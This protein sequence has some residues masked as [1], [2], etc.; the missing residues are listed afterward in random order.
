[1]SSLVLQRAL[2]LKLLFLNAILSIALIFL[3]RDAFLPVGNMLDASGMFMGRDFV[4]FWVGGHVFR[5]EDFSLL[6]DISAY[7]AEVVHSMGQKA[8]D[9]VWSYPPHAAFLSIPLSFFPYPVALAG[10]E[11]LTL[12][13]LSATL[14]PFIPVTHRRMAAL[15]LLS[16]PAVL[17]VLYMGQNGFLTGAC[18]IGSLLY[19]RKKPWLAGLY[20]GLL[21]IKPQLGLAVFIALLGLKAW[22]ALG[23]G[24]LFT[25]LTL[26]FSLLFHGT[27][28]WIQYLTKTLPHHAA[29]FQEHA[30]EYFMVSPLGCL[31]Q[32]GIPFHTAS[33]LHSALALMAACALPILVIRIK[34]LEWQALAVSIATFLLTPYAQGHD[35]IAIHAAMVLCIFSSTEQRVPEYFTFIFIALWS[36]PF[37]C[38]PEASREIGLSAFVLILSFVELFYKPHRLNPLLP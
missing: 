15:L 19:H 12:A 18:I 20:L 14:L 24:S 25:S 34:A 4:N 32:V 35:T 29:M 31:L 38:I 1:M 11:A 27:D 3:V 2:T 36:L 9:Y 6:F 16:S 5:A 10:F 33:F 28:V 8:G 7:N 37:I 13:F 22:R 17:P 21:T 30:F 23:W 26:G